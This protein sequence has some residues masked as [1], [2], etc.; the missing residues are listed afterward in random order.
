[1]E[2][3]FD[4]KKNIFDELL[5]IS[6]SIELLYKRL[7]QIECEQ[8]RD[9]EEYKK[10]YDYLLIAI[11]VE[12]DFIKN[13]MS[14]DEMYN[15][16]MHY[17]SSLKNIPKRVIAKIGYSNDFSKKTYEPFI[18][19]IFEQVDCKFNV[20]YRNKDEGF[21]LENEKY[22]LGEN[23]RKNFFEL[24]HL[25]NFFSFIDSDFENLSMEERK[26]LIEV[27]YFLYCNYPIAEA[28]F[29]EKIPAEVEFAKDDEMAATYLGISDDEYVECLSKH[30]SKYLKDIVLHYK[31]SSFSDYEQFRVI[32]K[33][34]FRSIVFELGEYE[35]R[36]HFMYEKLHNNVN[37]ADL[38]TDFYFIVE[39][40]KD[41]AYKVHRKINAKKYR[42]G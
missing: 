30:F 23:N 17:F 31:D 12:D 13:V 33:Y 27:K 1:M 38:N 5:A 6:N 22:I 36:Y 40:S 21:T 37:S 41:D 29:L 34:E 3:L 2:S 4:G 20:K 10:N 28:I 39:N 11:D 19:S 24:L 8:G 42:R 18:F 7:F 32:S 15:K 26:K 16:A 35:A 25:I 14:V 9:S